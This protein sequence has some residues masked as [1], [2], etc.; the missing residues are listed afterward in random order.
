MKTT[1]VNE[2]KQNAV[3]AIMT[4]FEKTN[5]VL[6]TDFRGLSV[7]EI[8]QLRNTL[9]ET[10]TEYRVVKNNYTRIAMQEMGLPDVSGFLFGPT[11]LALLR[12]EA[13]PVAKTARRRVGTHRVAPPCGF[14]AG[15]REFLRQSI[16][17]DCGRLGH[18][19]RR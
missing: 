2:A 13:G 3:K 6:F 17:S 4:L 14:H 16:T 5:D 10:E 19:S 1:K 7:A 11:A 15:R 18:R 12:K 8:T 9:R